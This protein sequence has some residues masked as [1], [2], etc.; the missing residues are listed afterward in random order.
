MRDYCIDAVS[1][2]LR[3]SISLPVPSCSVGILHVSHR[4]ANRRRLHS[5]SHQLHTHCRCTSN[6]VRRHGLRNN[7]E[8]HK[9]RMVRH[10][11]IGVHRGCFPLHP[12]E[13]TN[14]CQPRT[15]NQHQ[16][17]GNSSRATSWFSDTAFQLHPIHPHW[18]LRR[19][20]CKKKLSLCDN[21]CHNRRRI[22]ATH[23]PNRRM[24]YF[25]YAHQLLGHHLRVAVVRSS[26]ARHFVP[27][28]RQTHIHP[29]Q[30]HRTT[31]QVAINHINTIRDGTLKPI[32]R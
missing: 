20:T 23:I 24:R 17:T 22:G 13:N 16:P 31:R 11:R 5:F 12:V 30:T 21:H 2:S 15:R 8:K 10:R 25:G 28:E 1:V 6:M 9:H 3:A 19:F 14:Q 7:G 27:Q 29:F 4:T 32:N 26:S 18:I